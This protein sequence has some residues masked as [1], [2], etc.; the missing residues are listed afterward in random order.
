MECID[1]QNMSQET[2]VIPEGVLDINIGK[3]YPTKA[4]KE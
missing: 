2:S 1:S 3:I 4:L